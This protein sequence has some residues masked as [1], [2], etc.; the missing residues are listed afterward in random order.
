MTSKGGWTGS[1]L[2]EF[3]SEHRE[4]ESTLRRLKPH[5]GRGGTASGRNVLLALLRSRGEP[6]VI[7]LNET[8]DK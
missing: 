3:R 7:F 1:E 2:N 5:E 6:A 4:E 8:A